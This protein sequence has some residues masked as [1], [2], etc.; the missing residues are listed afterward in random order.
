M[1]PSPQHVKKR[2]TI[3]LYDPENIDHVTNC[4]KT[5][6][7]KDAILISTHILDEAP[8]GPAVQAEAMIIIGRIPIHTLTHSGLRKLRSCFDA[9][10][11]TEAVEV[12]QSYCDYYARELDGLCGIGV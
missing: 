3:I 9:S 1:L 8:L 11:D 2:R 10:P 6:G 12:A 7:Y 5:V 4:V